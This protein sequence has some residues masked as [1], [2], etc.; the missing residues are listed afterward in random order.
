MP[1]LLSINSVM[2]FQDSN[3]VT[4]VLKLF[5][6][7]YRKTNISSNKCFEISGF[8]VNL[9]KFRSAKDGHNFS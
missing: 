8:E 1:T 9:L 2:L 7:T 5:I 6:H 3:I 4:Y